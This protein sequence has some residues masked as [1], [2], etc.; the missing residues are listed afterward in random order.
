MLRALTAV[1]LY[2]SSPHEDASRARLLTEV[3][4]KVVTTI[5]AD[6]TSSLYHCLR[7]VVP[8]KL[9]GAC[10]RFL[11]AMVMQG[12]ESAKKLQSTFN[13]AYK[14]LTIFVNKSAPIAVGLCWW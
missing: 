3:G 12:V 8:S 7:T 2:T 9:I 11:A 4:E 6:H 10:L 13:F 5:L 1:L 14:P